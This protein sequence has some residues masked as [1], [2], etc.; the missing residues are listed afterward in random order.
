VDTR[1]LL[2]SVFRDAVAASDA[3]TAVRRSL[4]SDPPGVEEAVVIASGKAAAAMARGLATALDITDGVVVTTVEDSAPVPVVV[5]GHPE[6]NSGSVAGARRALELAAAAGEN[7][8]VVCLISGG[9][10]ALLAL[11]AGRLTLD[12]LV[13]T[14]RL[15]VASGADI[16]EMNAVRKHLSDI[17]GGRLAVAVRPARLITLVV[18]DV[19]GDAL[20]VIGSGPTVPDPTSFADAIGV[21]E[22]HRLLDQVPGGVVE[23]LRAGSAGLIEETPKHDHPDYEARIVAG[24]STA[25]SAAL[26]AARQRGLTAEVVTASLTGEARHAA[27]EAVRA[28]R[29]GVDL[30]VFAGETSVSVTGPGRGGRNQ[31]AA[32]AAALAIEETATTFL[33]GDTDGIDGATAAAGAIV[34]S[35]TIRRGRKAG[36]D[37]AVDLDN[38][39]SHRYLSA[40]GDLLITG[41]TGTNVADLWLVHHG[42]PG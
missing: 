27:V 42:L 39:D 34:D 36:R 13:A 6:P 41:R 3:E 32:L 1:E 31:E 20:D 38:N 35:G 26:D 18:S 19:P 5:A 21:L 22:R 16:G 2:T 23:H 40:T 8:T 30:L 4:E 17:K 37:A 29:P 7:T 15:L 33:A 24:C 9:S 11:P 14:T 28:R 25:A 10:S 12:D